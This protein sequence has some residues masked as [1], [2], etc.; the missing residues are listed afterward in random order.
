E[1]LPRIMECLDKITNEQIWWR[2]NETS[3]S[4]G[5][6][7]L[8]LCGNVRQWIG[9][10]LGEL[11]DHRKRQTEFDERRVIDKETL[12]SEL[13]NTML[14]AKD[15]ISKVSEQALLQTR[16]VQTFEET[17]LTILIHVTEHFSYHTG[18]IA[19]ITKMLTDKALGFYEGI[20]LE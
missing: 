14:M 5:N 3:N 15:V 20:P 10:G 19:Y 2:P 18:Q 12:K 7:V 17:G 16:P 8:H 9:T 4:I 11:P 13:S 6:L 1:S